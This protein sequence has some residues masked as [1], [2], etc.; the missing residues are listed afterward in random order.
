MSER[1]TVRL[2]KDLLLRAKRKAASERRTLASLIEEG[3]RLMMADNRARSQP[4]RRPQ[5]GAKSRGGL[6]P[7][8]DLVPLAPAQEVIDLDFV[9]RLRCSS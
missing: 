5:R 4:N 7:C 6:M 3:L 2:P 8:V 9:G 1:T